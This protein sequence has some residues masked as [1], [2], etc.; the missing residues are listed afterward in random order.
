LVSKETLPS[1]LF[2]TFLIY[3]PDPSCIQWS[4]IFRPIKELWC[5]C[6]WTWKI[7]R[8]QPVK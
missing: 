2:D 7:V 4:N 1:T 6:I 8:F 5:Y 3:Y